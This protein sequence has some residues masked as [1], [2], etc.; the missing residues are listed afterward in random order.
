MKEYIHEYDFYDEMACAIDD[1]N[2]EAILALSMYRKAERK[3][4]GMC[5]TENVN[6]EAF[7]T[8]ASENVFARIGRSVKELLEKIK[9]FFVDISD[10]IRGN[11][12]VVQN[13]I[14]EIEAMMVKDPSIARAKLTEGISNGTFKGKDI[15]TL[16]KEIESAQKLYEQNKLDE[17]TFANKVRKSF[18]KC[19]KYLKPIAG[20]ALSITALIALFPKV[21]KSI[22]EAKECNTKIQKM[23]QGFKDNIEKKKLEEPSR[24]VAIN[25]ALT[26][27][28]GICTKE[29]KDRVG[30][31]G[32]LGSILRKFRLSNLANKAMEAE[33]RN[34]QRGFE[35]IATNIAKDKLSRAAKKAASDNTKKMLD[36]MV[37]DKLK[38]LT[39]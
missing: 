16:Q 26:E 28:V 3:L 29:Y 33:A 20:V 27:T 18:E 13:E 37:N 12:K 4:D 7:L 34:K 36:T 22:G 23:I 31:M 10:K 2:R 38:E 35:T 5:V 25:R 17:D 32:K 39:P 6:R 14:N 24:A 15:V 19:D 11:D 30:F 1:A 8:E 9:K 21:V